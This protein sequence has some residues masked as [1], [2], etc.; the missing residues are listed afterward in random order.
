[1]GR[2]QYN[3]T[4]FRNK[5]EFGTYESAANPYTGISVPKFVPKFTLHYKPHTRTLNQEYLAVSAG[6]SE[7]RVIVVRHNAKVI[8]GLAVLLNGNVYDITKVSPDEGFGINKY[9][10]ITLKKSEKVGKK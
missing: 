7:T 8:K 3:P 4:D 5:A 6:E 1:M 2:K 9:D 10:F